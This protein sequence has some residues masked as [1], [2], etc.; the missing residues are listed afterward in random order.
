[1]ETKESSFHN[2]ILIENHS[3]IPKKT[4]LNRTNS[5]QTGIQDTTKYSLNQPNHSKLILSISNDKLFSSIEPPKDILT[6]LNSNPKLSLPSSKVKTVFSKLSE[7][8]FNQI[9]DNISLKDSISYETYVNDNILYS[10]SDKYHHSN[11][12]IIK[13]FLER[14]TQDNL[15]KKYGFGHHHKSISLININDSNGNTISTQS[16]KSFNTLQNDKKKNRKAS[17]RFLQNQAIFSQN[18][19]K[20]LNALKQ[21]YTNKENKYYGPKPQV[22]LTTEKLSQ[23]HIKL[24]NNT[25][26]NNIFTKLFEEKQNQSK[27]NYLSLAIEDKIDEYSKNNK[28]M[29]KRSLDVLVKRLSDN[30]SKEKQLKTSYESSHQNTVNKNS[31]DILILKLIHQYDI[32]MN[33]IFNAKTEDNITISYNQFVQL[34]FNMGFIKKNPLSCVNSIDKEYDIIQEAW[35]VL[36][37]KKKEKKSK[38]KEEEEEECIESHCVL[39]FLLSIL[40]LYKGKNTNESND[41]KIISKY[42]GQKN[43]NSRSTIQETPYLKKNISPFIQEVPFIN[44]EEYALNSP[45]VN[46]LTNH[47]RLLRDNRKEY[48]NQ[49]NKAIHRKKLNKAISNPVIFK[50]KTNKKNKNDICNIFFNQGEKPKKNRSIYEIYKLRKMNELKRK[51]ITKKN[52]ELKQ[53]TFFPNNKKP[54]IRSISLEE[55]KRLQLDLIKKTQNTSISLNGNKVDNNNDSD[56]LKFK[57]SFQPQ[58]T[59][60]NSNVFTN[61]PLRDD[62]QVING[63]E[64][65]A[66]AKSKRKDDSYYLNQTK[67]LFNYGKSNQ[68]V[69][70]KLENKEYLKQFRF[71]N[72]IK[73][74]KESFNKFNKT[75]LDYSNRRNDLLFAFEI[76]IEDE[77]KM[78]M[79]Y[80]DDDINKKTDL[81]CKINQLREDSKNQIISA[82]NAQINKING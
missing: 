15:K 78:L 23:Q 53:C 72:E 36:L 31:S 11:A 17:I 57:S 62:K 55:Q 71:D 10:Y 68:E 76:K 4:K 25:Q 3:T 74:N 33:N 70:N 45:F 30:H 38:G 73:H 34:L 54:H 80:K 32:E 49:Q 63:I 56:D 60:Y 64:R 59:K 18:K 44:Q 35:K 1:M 13:K 82:I 5:S 28:K 75:D 8:M 40:H 65:Y 27:K 77:I 66:I 67:D 19:A 69:L 46:Q 58:L 41:K 22:N 16:E 52:E 7:K 9:K 81:F 79:Y 47:F 39:L 61:N 50:P 21:Y 48:I 6:Q 24:D 43:R 51:A 2:K 29:N 42:K 37:R 14:T 26:Y 12:E 20:H